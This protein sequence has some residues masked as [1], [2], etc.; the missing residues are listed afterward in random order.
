MNLEIQ[1]PRSKHIRLRY[2]VIQSALNID[3]IAV[4]SEIHTKHI[5]ALCRQY[6]QFFMLHL[7]VRKVT[8]RLS[9]LLLRNRISSLASPLQVQ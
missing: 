9:V 4:C 1:L 3:I 7:V 5:N 8:T 2:K 6:V